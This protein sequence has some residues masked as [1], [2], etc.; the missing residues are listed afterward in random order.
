MHA[1]S[2]RLPPPS[3]GHRPRLSIHQRR[4]AVDDGQLGLSRPVGHPGSGCAPHAV[5]PGQVAARLPQQPQAALAVDHARAHGLG[6]RHRSAPQLVDRVGVGDRDA[7]PLLVEDV[8]GVVGR[9]ARDAPGRPVDHGHRLVRGERGGVDPHDRAPLAVHR[10]PR[11]PRLHGGELLG[12]FPDGHAGRDLGAAP[13]DQRELAGA[14]RRQPGGTVLQQHLDR[15]RPLG[16]GDQ[17]QP[18]RTEAGDGGHRQEAPRPTSASR[19]WPGRAAPARRPGCRRAGPRACGP[20]SSA[21]GRRIMRWASTLGAT[22]LTSS[23]VT[24]ARPLAAASAWA[25]AASPGCPA[26]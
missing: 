10:I 18:G 25:A 4:L 6:H 24:K 19:R 5:E 9:E 20:A 11:R 23:A 8:E 14:R 21:S 2:P 15:R 16:R 22:A 13:V 7:A 1:P 3:R 17:H 26:G 12:R